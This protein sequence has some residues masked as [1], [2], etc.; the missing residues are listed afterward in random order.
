M[1]ANCSAVE[2][3]PKALEAM[4]GAGVPIGAYANAFTII[5]KAFLSGGTTAEDL[6][7]REDMVPDIY[8]R[9]AMAWVDQGAT[10]IGGCCETGP[11]HIAEIAR[12]LRAAGHEIV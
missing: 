8:A 7:A 2:A 3:M 9:H 10:I 1:L 5:T 6:S 11:A 4:H 12:R